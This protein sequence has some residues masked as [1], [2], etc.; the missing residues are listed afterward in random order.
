MIDRDVEQAIDF[1]EAVSTRGRETDAHRSGRCFACGRP[2]QW[3][4]PHLCTN[5]ECQIA[6][7]MYRTLDQVTSDQT[8]IANGHKPSYAAVWERLGNRR[9]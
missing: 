8:L 3:R 2:L 9:G 5:P 7:G 1:R 4:R 6:F